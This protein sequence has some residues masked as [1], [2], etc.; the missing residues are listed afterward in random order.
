[1]P[2][3][4]VRAFDRLRKRLKRRPTDQEVS[5]E[6]AR[7]TNLRVGR[8]ANLR[9]GRSGT[10]RQDGTIFGT[11]IRKPEESQRES[12]STE[13]D[14]RDSTEIGSRVSPL[15]NSVPVVAP[16]PVAPVVLRLETP[17]KPRYEAPD[18]MY[19]ENLPARPTPT[20]SAHNDP[21]YDGVRCPECHAGPYTVANARKH[22]VSAHFYRT[23]GPILR[24]TSWE[25]TQR[26]L[27]QRK[28][29]ERGIRPPPTLKEQGWEPAPETPEQD[30]WEPAPAASSGAWVRSSKTPAQL[31][32]E[33][34]GFVKSSEW[35]PVPESDG[36]EVVP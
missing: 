16:Q 3:D 14:S 26:T 5:Q 20:K 2:S 17:D 27:E 18:A 10:R 11:G 34:E 19:G 7:P 8:L 29:R 30:G 21:I 22:L 24:P 9:V 13:N 15:D 36:W 25:P 31:A 6:V 33:R 23:R 32:A 28:E 12:I 4:R 35:E 1:M